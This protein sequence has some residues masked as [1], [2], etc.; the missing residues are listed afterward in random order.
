MIK[1]NPKK[2][3]KE[4]VFKL[5]RQSVAFVKKVII[6]IP[7]DYQE[8]LEKKEKELIIKD[9]NNCHNNKINKKLNQKE[10]NVEEENQEMRNYFKNIIYNINKRYLENI[11]YL[12]EKYDNS[13]SF[14]LEEIITSL[15]EII[16]FL[17]YIGNEYNIKKIDSTEQK[18]I[19]KTCPVCLDNYSNCHVSPC[20]HMF[21]LVCVKKFY[22]IRCPLCRKNMTGIFEYP[23]LKFSQNNQEN[24]INQNNILILEIDNN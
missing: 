22:D 18:E 7:K 21:C 9:E 14:N 20:G 1:L 19:A 5:I 24:N 10:F 8:I 2:Y 3:F 23:N 11:I 12:L 13:F 15:K 4:I 16:S 17:N 6:Q